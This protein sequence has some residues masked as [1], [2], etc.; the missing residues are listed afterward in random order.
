MR[1][2]YKLQVRRRRQ[3]LLVRL[4]CLLLTAPAGCSSW[5]GW[6]PFRSA[7]EPTAPVDTLVMH[8]DRLEPQRWTG[9]P[10][11]LQQLAGAKELYGSEQYEKAGKAFHKL[12]ENKKNTELIAEEARFYEAECLYH[13]KRYPKAADT[14][15]KLLQDFPSGAH[16]EPS[17]KRMYDIANYWL[18]DTR[19]DMRREKE[20]RE[21]KHWVA[22]PTP[23]VHFEKSKPLLDETGRAEEKLEQVVYNDVTGPLA[24]EAMFLLASVKFYHE[25]Y[26]EADHYFTQLVQMHPNSKY[27]PRAVELAII[28]KHLSTGG[29][30]YDGRKTAEARQ[31]IAQAQE[32]YP[33]FTRERQDFLVRQLH[34][35]TMQQAEKDYKIADFYRRTDHPGAAYFCYDIVRRR[36]PNTP[37]AAQASQRMQELLATHPIM[38]ATAVTPASPQAPA[39]PPT[40]AEQ[41]PMPRSVPTQPG[42]PEMAPAPRPV[43]TPTN[44]LPDYLKK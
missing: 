13:Q 25:D 12:A 9:D 8:G 15:A 2:H 30:D 11:T 21:G 17:M 42:Q 32:R 27:A 39:Q 41:A 5:S 26:K 3:R 4:A 40:G 7:P 44:N 31:L 6:H 33:E 37:Y 1:S 23:F 36:Y 19:E 24:P 43:P 38:Q 29:S 34:G 18:D 22:W 35:I 16:R 10:K 14:Y 28:S 20:K